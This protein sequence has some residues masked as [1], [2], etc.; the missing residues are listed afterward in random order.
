[1]WRSARILVVALSALGGASALAAN[2]PGVTADEI[3]FGQTIPLSGPASAY[4]VLSRAETAYFK[5]INEQ[6]GINGRKLNF[7][8][9]D[10]AYSPPRTLEQTRRL[11]EQEQVAFMF[12]GVGTTASIAVRPYFNDNKVPQLFAAFGVFDKGFAWTVPY[13]QP[14][15]AEAA[16]YARYALSRNP[17]AKIAV[18]Y[19]NDDLGKTYLKGF[20]DGLGAE[21]AG[22]LVKALSYEV[23][24]PTVDSQV[25]SL[26]ASGADV[27]FIAGS[28]KF[29]AQAI[30][31]SYDLGWDAT[32]FIAVV[33]AT[34][35]TVLKP[36]GLEK[37]K[38]V[39]T[40]ITIK[41]ISDPRWKDEDDVKQYQAFV[42]KYLT[43]AD[44][45]SN[46]AAYAYQ[47][48]ALLVY[49]LKACGDD[50]SRENIL[51]KATH[52]EGLKLPL[53]LPGVLAH[54]SPEDYRLFHQF[55]LEQFDGESWKLFGDLI[56]N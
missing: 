40:A 31:K 50:L 49:V 18:L 25:T 45:T 27:F 55:Q 33:A 5:M 21:H 32:R 36:A 8:S 42:A 3:K 46:A 52:I 20:V 6:G 26:Q 34:I 28:P 48:A 16:I 53:A 30:R 51:A 37:S 19:Q 22:A 9:A 41:D 17:N 15:D 1:M 29:T 38:G 47:S 12:N 54:N 10:D 7:I 39:I 24:E 2:A 56:G 35:P 13:F 11:V 4:S 23:S 44:A 14:Y 43:P